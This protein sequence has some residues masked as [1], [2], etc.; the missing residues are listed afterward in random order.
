MPGPLNELDS[1]VSLYESFYGENH[2]PRAYAR[3]FSSTI[4]AHYSAWSND[5][6]S[7]ELWYT[8]K[9]K[10][11]NSHVTQI[12]HCPVNQLA[13]LAKKCSIPIYL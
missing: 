13:V 8:V 2:I 1:P 7:Q 4:F 9:N 10:S 6:I 12:L 5:K 3:A 11:K